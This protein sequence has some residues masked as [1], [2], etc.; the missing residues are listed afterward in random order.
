MDPPYNSIFSYI[1]CVDHGTILHSPLE[2]CF[3]SHQCCHFLLMKPSRILIYLWWKIWCL[4]LR[5][6]RFTYVAETPYMYIYIH[7][8]SLF[9][10]LFFA[11]SI[12]HFRAPSVESSG[13]FNGR[14][15]SWWAAS[16]WSA[17]TWAPTPPPNWAR[18][19]LRRRKWPTRNSSSGRGS[20]GEW[21]D[22]SGI[23]KKNWGPFWASEKFPISPFISSFYRLLLLDLNLW[24]FISMVCLGFHRWEIPK[25]F[26]TGNPMVLTDFV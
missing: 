6:H 19:A 2:S 16:S 5:H 4:L 9:I 1:I 11:G 22:Q 20:L 21:S 7:V 14:R 18:E 15:T 23:S 10:N 17:A 13:H 3:H 25:W 24:I 26:S 8:L 12:H